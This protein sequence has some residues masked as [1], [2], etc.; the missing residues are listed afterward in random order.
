MK[1]TSSECNKLLRRLEEE[2]T[3][4]LDEEMSNSYFRAAV[5]EDPEQLRPEYDLIKMA[6]KIDAVD[7]EIIR[8]KHLLNIFNASTVVVDGMTIDQV[9]IRLP[10][11]MK[12]KTKLF[13]MGASQK[14]HR[15]NIS[16]NIIDYEYANFDPVEA[17]KMFSEVSEKINE[18][19]TA[20]DTVNNTV[21]FEV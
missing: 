9:L 12:Q 3:K 14:K 17:S 7:R 13:R 4:L 21:T 20:L 2:K 8:V 5:S 18:L 11:L 6:E 1:I 10:Q 19:Q 15:A 16:G